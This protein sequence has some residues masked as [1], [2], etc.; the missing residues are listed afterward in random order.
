MFLKYAWSKGVFGTPTAFVNGVMLDT[1]PMTVDGWIELLDEVYGSQ[2]K[3]IEA[4]L[5]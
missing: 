5:Q 2:P 1:V 3:A 4:F